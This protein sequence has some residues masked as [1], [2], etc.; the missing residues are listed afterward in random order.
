MFTKRAGFIVLSFLMIA[1]L[2][3]GCSKDDDKDDSPTELTIK[4]NIT[5][6][7]VDENGMA[8]SGAAIKYVSGSTSG[9]TTTDANGDYR[10]AD[11]VIGTYTID[12][13][14][15]GFT[16]GRT[17]AVITAN[18]A[19]VSSIILNSLAVMEDRVENIVTADVIKTSGASVESSVD[20]NLSTGSGMTETKTTVVSATIA[21][22]TVIT[23]NDVVQTGNVSLAVTPMEI[24][25]VPPP[26]EDEMP[27]GAAI[28]EPVDAKFDKPVEV[29]LPVEIKLPAGLELPVK[30]FEDGTWKD[31]GTATIDESGLGADAEV[32]EFGQI[33]VQPDV[34]IDEVAS[35][36]VETEGATTQVD[37]NDSV[38]EAEVTDTVEI[39]NLP[40]GV[41]QEYALSL[42]EKMKG[43]SLGEART[44]QLELPGVSKSVAK[45]AS[46]LSP[47]KTEPWDQTCTMTV[48]NNVTNESITM[49]IELS[50]I[51]YP[52]EIEYTYNQKTVKIK[53]TQTWVG[54]GQ[55]GV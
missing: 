43:I 49:N 34:T 30:K 35:A 12:A 26:P 18:G 41:T 51:N 5:G 10:F 33:A 20:A 7:V 44:L 19:I 6:S 11:L 15:S 48:V 16:F 50:G 36:P 39:T 25:D 1:F 8:I 55:G 52:F 47:E 14:K 38:V 29:K 27:M 32:S 9:Q 13:T 2:T 21:P 17:N 42:I 4:Y 53:C 45:V 24:N 22:E 54:H 28:F 31:V 23:I 3:F 46:P 40:A 37:V